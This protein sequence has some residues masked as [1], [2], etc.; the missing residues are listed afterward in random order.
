M[1]P[2][3]STSEMSEIWSDKN[4]YR[5]WLKI[6]LYACE[7]QEKLGIIPKKSLTQLENLLILMNRE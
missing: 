3:Y 2:R 4:K 5:L 1:I 6:E 7:I